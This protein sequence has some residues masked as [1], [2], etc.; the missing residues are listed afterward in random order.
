[1]ERLG[2]RSVGLPVSFAY[3]VV[4]SVKLPGD[5]FEGLLAVRGIL[6]SLLWSSLFSKEA[7]S[8]SASAPPFAPLTKGTVGWREEEAATGA[9]GC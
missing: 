5:R 3:T 6:S 7:N 1:M 8:G 2:V 9:A 4:W